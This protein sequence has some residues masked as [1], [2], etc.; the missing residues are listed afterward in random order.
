[1]RCLTLSEALLRG[2]HEVHFVTNESGVPWLQKVLESSPVFKHLAIQHSL[3]TDVIMEIDPDWVVVDSYVIPI[4]EINAFSGRARILAIVDG[5]AR[6][7]DADLYV[8]HNLGAETVQ[9]PQLVSSRILAGSKYALVRDAV[10]NQRKAEPWKIT[11]PE[12]H[13][14]A[15]MGGSDP[16][17]TICLAG[18]V[19]ANL[20]YSFRSTIIASADWQQSVSELIADNPHCRVI[21]PTPDLPALL[22]QADVAISA[23]G[24]SAWE[25]CTL[26]IPSILL[27]VVDNQDESLER[28]VVGGFALGLSRAEATKEKLTEMLQLLLLDEGLRKELT[29]RCFNSFDGK[30]K[31]RVVEAMERQLETSIG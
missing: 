9:W 17:G 28:L 1:M 4:E 5:D 18:E 29:Q 22:G 23:A 11:T 16:T 26:G 31:E 21:P 19:L 13:I 24:T 3:G 2:G 6:G 8:D 20:D 12:T 14:L 7:I 25:L 10:L 30:G 27:A 15:F